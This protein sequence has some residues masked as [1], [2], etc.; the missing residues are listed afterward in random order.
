MW[1]GPGRRKLGDGARRFENS[2]ASWF[3][4]VGGL[5]PTSDRINTLPFPGES[6]VVVVCRRCMSEDIRRSHLRPID[7]LVLPFLFV[8]VRCRNCMLRSY[9]HIVLLL[10]GQKRLDSGLDASQN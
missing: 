5:V 2:L 8:P 4:F 6:E 7:L 1:S 3:D 9:R 10:L